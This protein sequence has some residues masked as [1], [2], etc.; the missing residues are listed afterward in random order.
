MCIHGYLPCVFT[1]V[2]AH[3]KKYMA[4]RD[5][6]K[7][8]LNQP[9]PKLATELEDDVTRKSAKMCVWVCATVSMYTCASMCAQTWLS[10][11]MSTHRTP[12]HVC[13]NTQDHGHACAR[14]CTL[15]HRQKRKLPRF[16]F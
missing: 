4:W 7:W 2:C 8:C 1:L 15:M 10:V 14:A 6:S 11:Y 3:R 13:T 9:E 5:V 12:I 16:H